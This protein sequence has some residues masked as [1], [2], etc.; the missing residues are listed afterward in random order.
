MD[1]LY[2]ARHSKVKLGL[3]LYAEALSDAEKVIELNPSSYL[4]YELKHAALHGAHR[5][6]DAFEALT[7]MLSKLNDTLD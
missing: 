2:F 3:K 1:Y 7:I 5:H 4:G 6:Y